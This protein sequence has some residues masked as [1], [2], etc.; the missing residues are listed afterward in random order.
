MSQQMPP[1]GQQQI[2]IPQRTYARLSAMRGDANHRGLATSDL[3][4]NEFVLTQEAGFEPL[5]MVM[6]TSIYHVGWQTTGW[7]QSQEVGILTQAMYN[8]RGLAMSRMV[9]EAKVLGADGVVGVH[10]EIA[11][12]EWETELAEFVAVGTAIRARNGKSYRNVHGNP[13]TSDLSGQDF[14]TLLKAGYAPAGLVMGNCVYHIAHQSMSQ[15]FN[16]IGRNVEMTNYTFGLYEARDLAMG[17][18]QAEASALQA[19]NVVNVNL[20]QG[21]YQW[22]SHVIEFFVLGTAVV[23]F[24][25]ERPMPEPS[26]TLSL[27][28]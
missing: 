24:P 16:Q 22:E 18:M 23:P 19:T 26:L 17:R 4:V 21:S 10:L 15:W 12:Q 8:A 27:N 1:Q 14:W 2:T 9:E 28:S 11:T 13:F 25:G 7:K 5:G 20:S 3:S 6:G